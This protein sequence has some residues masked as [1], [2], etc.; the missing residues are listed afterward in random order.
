[1]SSPDPPTKKLQVSREGQSALRA[2]SISHRRVR[3]LFG[4]RLLI[5]AGIAVTGAVLTIRSVPATWVTLAGAAWAAINSVGLTWWADAELQRAAKLQEKFEVEA[6]RLPWNHVA[7]GPE[8]RSAD[9]SA[10]SR[11]FK[12]GRIDS[13]WD[14]V[15]AF[16]PPFDVLARQLTNLVW[17]ARVRRRYANVVAVVIGAWTLAGAVVGVAGGFTV[18]QIF[19]GWYVPSLGGLLFGLES[20]RQQLAVAKERERVADYAEKQILEAARRPLDPALR[21]S[22][23]TL[24]RQLQDVLFRTRN[25]APRVPKFPFYRLSYER[26]KLNCRECTRGVADALATLSPAP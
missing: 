26:D 18:A 5:S 22:L 19:V 2:M 10:L 6:F 15:P 1:M 20:I 9:R 11:K 16:D 24:S 13:D 21:A 8:V 4:A 25:R 23:V 3:L 14:D 12:K 17:G 7:A